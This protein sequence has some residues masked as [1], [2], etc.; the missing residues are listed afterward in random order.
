MSIASVVIMMTP[1]SICIALDVCTCTVFDISLCDR[2]SAVI[3]LFVQ[4]LNGLVLEGLC[5]SGD[6]ESC[7]RLKCAFDWHKLTCY[8]MLFSC[9]ADTLTFPFTL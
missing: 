8:L 7:F 3:G 4:F 5:F 9:S 6:Q 1:V 2:Q